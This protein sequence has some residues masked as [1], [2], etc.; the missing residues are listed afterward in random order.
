M[1]AADDDGW[2]PD[3][4][5]T[6]VDLLEAH[7]EASLA[8]GRF[9][10]R[11]LEGEA[12][13]VDV[14]GLA[15]SRLVRMLVFFW[16]ADARLPHS[17]GYGGYPIYGLF[18]TPFAKREWPV[19]M[20]LSSTTRH[21][22]RWNAPD[23]IFIYHLLQETPIVTTRASTFYYCATRPAFS[24]P[25]PAARYVQTS[26]LRQHA[27]DIVQSVAHHVDYVKVAQPASSRLAVAIS[28][29]PKLVYTV[30]RHEAAVLRRVARR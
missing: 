2:D 1:W 10:W 24:Q 16:S 23:S 22:G 27:Q 29:A 30:A 6:L 14:D 8:C 9:Q 12:R 26:K 20:K 19:A 18:R 17:G 5:E 13:Y 7:P 28:L 4:I 15:G 3:W 21:R 11:T 25:T